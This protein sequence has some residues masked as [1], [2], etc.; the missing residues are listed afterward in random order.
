MAITA[1][2]KILLLL[3]VLFVLGFVVAQILQGGRSGLLVEACRESVLLA[4]RSKHL[5]AQPECQ[6]AH[7]GELFV[8][9][10]TSP[11]EETKMLSS[12]VG[13]ELADCWYAFGEGK[14]QP[15]RGE[16]VSRTRTVCFVCSEFSI[17]KG[18]VLSRADFAEWAKANEYTSF[19]ETTTYAD[20][21][22]KGTMVGEAGDELY[23]VD[24]LDYKSI[25]AEK[26]VVS[27][28]ASLIFPPEV[29]VLPKA[30][31]PEGRYAV[32]LWNNAAQRPLQWAGFASGSSMVF[33]APDDRVSESCEVVFRT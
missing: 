28:G 13:K 27:A 9:D 3:V 4:S 17:P 6:T 22:G 19:G 26:N 7:R 11:G 5:F 14:E 1:L 23:F 24:A 8:P 25:F 10:G 16:W 21:L 18:K 29:A 31:L 2:V 12:Q 20:F 33:V 30:S 15:W 32:V